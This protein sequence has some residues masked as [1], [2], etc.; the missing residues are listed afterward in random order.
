MQFYRHLV[1]RSKK[2]GTTTPC[3]LVQVGLLEE[4]E[5]E[6]MTLRQNETEESQ[7]L[8]IRG[9]DQC[10]SNSSRGRSEQAEENRVCRVI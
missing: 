9:L 4:N 7:S 1:G 5:N 6:C 3:V 10:L 2:R 8:F